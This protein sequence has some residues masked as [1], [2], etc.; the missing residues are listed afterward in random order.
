MRR[1]P[2][3]H[4]SS[5]HPGRSAPPNRACE[6]SRLECMWLWQVHPPQ[7]V[8]RDWLSEGRRASRMHRRGPNR[9]VLVSIGQEPGIAKTLTMS[10]Y[11]VGTREGQDRLKR[12]R[13]PLGL[14]FSL[15]YQGFRD[16]FQAPGLTK[17]Q[18]HAL[19]VTP[20]ASRT[21]APRRIPAFMNRID[22]VR[23]R[24]A[25]DVL[26]RDGGPPASLHSC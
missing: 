6:R 9:G 7:S 12:L 13:I 21:H 20:R 26:Q 15:F 1:S 4:F 10:D 14:K 24:K 22:V 23:P 18:H 17:V 25:E 5:L 3:V 16:T 2:A 11:S 19:F 8:L